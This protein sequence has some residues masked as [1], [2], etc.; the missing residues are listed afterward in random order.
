MASSMSGQDE[1]NF[2]LWSTA[3]A[4]KI[5][6]PC[7]LWITHCFFMPHFNTFVDQTCSAKMA[8]YLWLQ[9]KRCKVSFFE[10]E[11]FFI[12]PKI[13]ILIFCK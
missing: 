6:L 3:R 1:P 8:R 7:P 11:L 2:E 10:G 13:V 9:N 5:A 12:I 4:G